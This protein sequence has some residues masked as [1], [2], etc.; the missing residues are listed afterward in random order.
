M[1][2]CCCLLLLLLPAWLLAAEPEVRIEQRLVP[3]GEVLAG[4][5]VE[6]QID[7]LVDTWFTD[8]PQLAALSLPGAVVSPPSSEAEHLNRQ[9]DGKPF[10]G[11][12][13][14]YRVTPQNPGRFQIPALTFTVHPGQASV[15]VTLSSQPLAFTAKG[16]PAQSGA[17]ADQVLVA[18]DVTFTQVVTR[19]HDPLRQG[20]TITRKL[21][22]VAQGTEAMLLPATPM[23]EVDGLKRYVAAPNVK[24]LTD[25]R[26]GTTGG[27]RE[28]TVS[29]VVSTPGHYRLPAIEL[30][31]RDA[32][33]AELHTLSVP[34]VDIEATQGG[35]QAPFSI[36]DDLRELGQ[37]GRVTI[38]GHWLGLA[39]AVLLLAGLG[40]VLRAKGTSA[41][42]HWRAWRAQRRQR[43][44][45]SAEYA[46]RQARQQCTDQPPRLDGLY[47]WA[48][49]ATGATTL[50]SLAELFPRASDNRLPAFFSARYSRS[51]P[52]TPTVDLEQLLPRQ[53]RR[54]IQQHQVKKPRRHGLKPLNP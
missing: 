47:L 50:C 36:T 34:A 28:D 49:R 1:S 2:R 18:N 22:V 23:A 12:R 21:R 48:R 7:L 26:G 52:G 51:T 46:W 37:R 38:A 43:W 30:R 44:L 54:Q 19:S 41:L 25:G 24:P 15:P 8:A 4:A 29:Y 9:F 14:R 5:T 45:D 53:T 32:T 31:W 42:G 6:L 35:Y 33:S 27:V 11:L 40:W 17:P 3:A 16:A 20:D 13:F 39:A 10:F